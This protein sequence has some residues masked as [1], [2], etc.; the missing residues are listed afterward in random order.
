MYTSSTEARELLSLICK[1]QVLNVVTR[2]RQLFMIRPL[3]HGDGACPVLRDMCPGP[4][5]PAN[6]GAAKSRALADLAD[7]ETP[8]PLAVDSGRR[9]VDLGTLKTAHVYKATGTSSF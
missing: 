8:R 6:R 3:M 9:F 1:G 2:V 4:E 7:S 5:G